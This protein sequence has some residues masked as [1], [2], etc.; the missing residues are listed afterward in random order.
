LNLILVAFPNI[1]ITYPIIIYRAPLTG[2]IAAYE[3]DVIVWI[4]CTFD[5]V[6]AD[7][8]FEVKDPL[9]FKEPVTV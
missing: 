8:P 9:R 3:A 1:G 2:V 6:T 4:E 7:N 5:D